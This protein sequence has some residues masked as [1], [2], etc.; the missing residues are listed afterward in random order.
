M[1]MAIDAC[2]EGH[3]YA[4]HFVEPCSFVSNQAYFLDRWL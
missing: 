1:G 3:F 2:L 4:E